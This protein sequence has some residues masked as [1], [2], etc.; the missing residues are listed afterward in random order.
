[1]QAPAAGGDHVSGI[2]DRRRC[3]VTKHLMR[4]ERRSA[5]SAAD[6]ARRWLWKVVW[7]LFCTPTPAPFHA[8]RGFILRLF[9]ATVEEGVRVYSSARIWAPWNLTL[10]ARACLGPGVD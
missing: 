3:V 7:A 8:W 1:M 4:L 6:K 10:K 5:P 2:R 9:G